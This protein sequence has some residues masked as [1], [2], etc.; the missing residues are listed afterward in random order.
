MV[1]F[2]KFLHRTPEDV[3]RAQ[4]EREE[5]QR[6]FESGIAA[7]IAELQEMVCAASRRGDLSDWER[8]FVGDLAVLGNRPG[9]LIHGSGLLDLSDAQL[10]NLR[11]LAGANQSPDV[12]AGASLAQRLRRFER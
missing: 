9:Q 5:A 6:D 7:R 8:Q 1:D 2:S 10:A 4:R 3:Q 11:R 12:A